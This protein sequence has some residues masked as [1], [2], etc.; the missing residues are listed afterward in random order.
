MATLPPSPAESEQ[1]E[2]CH[3]SDDVKDLSALARVILLAKE[4]Q[5]ATACLLFIAWQA[6]FALEAYTAITGMC[7]A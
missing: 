7:G 6:G 4:N 3:L 1:T 2:S 5:L